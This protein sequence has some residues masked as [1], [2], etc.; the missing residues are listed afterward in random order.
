MARPRG[1][2]V[3]PP[4]VRFWV[5]VRGGSVEDCWLWTASLNPRGYGRFFDGTRVIQAHR[6]AYEH[7]R[8]FI[9]DGLVL[10]HL[11]MTPAC[12]NP[13]HLEPVTHA[14]N[15][16]RWGRSVTTCPQGHPYDEKNTRIGSKGKT[17]RACDARAARQRRAAVKSPTFPDGQDVPPVTADAFLGVA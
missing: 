17:C 16:A 6:F 15:V 3:T 10:D 11:C 13:W 9:P 14:V 5:K 7:L 12:V 4:A 8:S 2:G 1:S